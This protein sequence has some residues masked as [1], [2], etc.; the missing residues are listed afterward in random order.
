MLRGT[1][2]S[3]FNGTVDFTKI[4]GNFDFVIL[5]C[6]YGG[7]YTNQDDEEFAR[8]AAECER[9]GIPYGVYLYSYANSTDGAKGEADH[10]LRLISGK[11]IPYGVWY[12]LEDPS[13]TSG[14]DELAQ[15]CVTYLDKI[16]AAGFH[17]GIYANLSWFENRLTSP[18]LT[19]YD[20]WV[21]QWNSTCDYKGSYG[22]WQYTSDGSIDGLDGR[23]DLNYAYKDYENAGDKPVTPPIVPPPVVPPVPSTRVVVTASNG[24]NVREG[25][26]TS[27][28]VITAVHMARF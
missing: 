7:D 12:D 3:E 15:I 8:G 4:K 24:L 26:G 11:K 2:I 28:N 10:T 13:I 1:D 27:Y 21:A 5:R 17:A 14:T 25:A 6:G 23:F 9:L 18:L 19:K 16:I 20:K 22:I